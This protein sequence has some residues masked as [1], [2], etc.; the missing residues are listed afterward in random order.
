MASTIGSYMTRFAL[1]I[2][3]WNLTGEATPIALLAVFTELPALVISPLAGA[4]ADRFSRKTLMLVGDTVAGLSTIIILL[5]YLTGN[6]ALWH[7]YATG[8]LNGAFSRLQKL[9]YTA[10]ITMLV[11]Q[12]GYTRASGMGSV[13]H[14]GSVIIAPA[15]A[16]ALYPIV[17]LLGILC[18]DLITFAIALTMVLFVA[19]PNPSTI[20][21]AKKHKSRPSL[22]QEIKFAFDYLLTR[23]SLLTLVLIATLFQFSH[24]IGKALYS[25][26]I[27]ARTGNDAQV[28]GIISA[29]AGIGGI[30]GSIMVSVWRMKGRKINWFLGG[31]M[32]AGVAKTLFGIGQSVFI[33]FP[34]QFLS[35]INFPIMG[36]AKQGIILT[37]VE[38]DL[39]G[40]VI[41][42][43]STFVGVASPL[44]KLMAG[45]LA[46]QVFTP[47]M[48]EGGLLTGVFGRLFGVGEGSGIALL[49]TL[50][51]IGLIAVGV[52]GYRLSH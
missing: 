38:A 12:E 16:G 52:L 28:L 35:S 5:L 37:K 9:A 43:S 11:P 8:A 17:D 34:S 20:V 50:S 47:A 40:R 39:Q 32:G 26:M 33:W 4:I 29:A 44:A 21:K 36:S 2:W 42:M 6:L 46:D 19:I 45:P 51:S 25:P 18:V 30:L 23:P 15:V 7:L 3:L 10:S 24:D 13:L 49:Y 14:Y 31:M 27:L 41:A 22:W 48:A 1:T